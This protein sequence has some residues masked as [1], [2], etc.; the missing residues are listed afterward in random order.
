VLRVEQFCAIASVRYSVVGALALAFLQTAHALPEK[1]IVTCKNGPQA[2]KVSLLAEK[3]IEGNQLY[4][5]FGDQK[6]KAFTDLPGTDFVGRIAMAKCVKGVLVFA[7]DYGSPYIKGAAIRLRHSGHATIQRERIDFAEK[8]TPGWLYISN[9][10]MKIV[11][12]NTGV[13]ATSKYFVYSSAPEKGASD[14]AAEVNA[15]PSKAAVFNVVR[16]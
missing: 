14:S 15:L 16:L 4:L 7:L 5:Q 9:E 13:G 3:S 8:T 6:E 2:T 12:R 1:T 11:I 10:Q